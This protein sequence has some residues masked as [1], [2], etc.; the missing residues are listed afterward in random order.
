MTTR[1][2]VAQAVVRFL[3]A[4][5]V[6]RDGVETP[7]FAGCLGI[8]GH[9]NVA[10]VGQALLEREQRRERAA[11]PSTSCATTRPAT[12]RRWC[13]RRSATPGTA[14][15]S[16]PRLHRLGRPGLDEHGH[17][18]RAGDDQPD[19]GAAAA[20]RRVRD[21]GRP[22]RCCRSSRTRARYDV[23]VNDCF[24]PVSRFWDRINRPEQLPAVAA[25]PRCGC[26]PTRPRPARSRSRCRRTCRPRRGTGPTTCSPAASGTCRGSR[27]PSRRAGPRGRR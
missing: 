9:G 26:S 3:E 18:R 1:L 7:F 24:K 16:P 6:E 20:R 23:S 19:P 12:S 22:T 15:G 10:G 11:R 17:R 27:S 8:F 13:T 14:T 2:T 4:Q 21:P 25:R 5:Y